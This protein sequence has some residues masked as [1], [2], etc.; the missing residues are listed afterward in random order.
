MEL[1]YGTDTL[2]KGWIYLDGFQIILKWFVPESK[3]NSAWYEGL[4]IQVDISV[5]Y[6]CRL[7]KHT[8]II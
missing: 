2:V 8:S 4:Y 7:I 1:H 3:F 6:V 5:L